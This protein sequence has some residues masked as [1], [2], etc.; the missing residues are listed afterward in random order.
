MSRTVRCSSRSTQTGHPGTSEGTNLIPGEQDA[1]A[2]GPTRPQQECGSTMITPRRILP[3]LLCLDAAE[4]NAAAAERHPL[5]VGH[6]GL[7]R[8]APENTLA[9]F[10]ACLELRLGFEFDV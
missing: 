7:L 5:I 6:R 1:N 8:H 10:R 9:S 3:L 2:F 4:A